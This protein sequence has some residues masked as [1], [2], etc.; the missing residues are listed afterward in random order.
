MVHESFIAGGLN[1]N[2]EDA[3]LFAVGAALG[4]YFISH[5]KKTGSAV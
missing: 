5:M 4:W 1:M 2:V 3:V